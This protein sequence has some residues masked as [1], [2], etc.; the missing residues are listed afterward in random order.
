MTDRGVR[1]LYVLTGGA[2]EFCNSPKQVRE[3]LPCL[4]GNLRTEWRGEA[5]HLL[6]RSGDRRWLNGTV[7]EWL[8]Q[9][10]RGLPGAP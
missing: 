8:E 5:D 10:A 3:A 1:F 4:N 6:A 7:L 2:I 9:W